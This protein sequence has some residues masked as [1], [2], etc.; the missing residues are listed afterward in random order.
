MHK[1]AITLL[2]LLCR[3]AVTLAQDRSKSIAHY[4]AIL[5]DNR[6]ARARRL[7][8]RRE[9]PCTHPDTIDR[10]AASR[11]FTNADKTTHDSDMANGSGM[12]RRDRA[13]ALSEQ[14]ARTPSSSSSRVRAPQGHATNVRPA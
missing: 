4:K 14:P 8:R 7:P 5:D 2:K 13:A 3:S 11:L 1:S 12:H 10:L 6:R 9:S